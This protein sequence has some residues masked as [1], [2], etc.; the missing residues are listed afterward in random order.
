MT[1]GTAAWYLGELAEGSQ[2]ALVP[3]LGEVRTGNRSSALEDESGDEPVPP[4]PIAECGGQASA[5]VVCSGDC[6]GAVAN[7]GAA[8]VNLRWTVKR[9]RQRGRKRS[10]EAGSPLL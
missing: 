7:P 2:G 4:P 3:A 8:S 5:C 6:G 9:T 1:W 10:R